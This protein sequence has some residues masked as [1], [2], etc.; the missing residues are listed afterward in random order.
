VNGAVVAFAGSHAHSAGLLA[1]ALGDGDTSRTL[2]D[3]AATVYRRLGAVR[4]L[5][6]V[7]ERRGRTALTASMRREGTLWHLRF[8]GREATVPH[9]K[10]LADLAQVVRAGGTEVHVLQLVQSADRSGSSGDVV[11]RTALESYRRRLADLEEEVDAATLDN[12]PVR[13]ELAEAER[14]LLLAEL[15]RVSGAHHR[16][17]QF[18]NHPAERARKAVAG[19]IRDALRKLESAHP[20]L[21]VHLQRTIV[22]GIYCRYRT[23]GTRWEIDLGR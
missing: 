17:R 7:T 15:G 10:G 19:R 11:D 1:A 23:D 16:S 22:T 2:L 12:D 8:G 20:E 18:A 21:A 9:S 13:R 3:A 5:A 6:E 14:E 4:W